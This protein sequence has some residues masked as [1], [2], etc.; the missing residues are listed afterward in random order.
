MAN[1]RAGIAIGGSAGVLVRL[2]G[3][4]RATISK[5]LPSRCRFY[6]SCA[7]YAQEAIQVHGAVRGGWMGIRRILRCHPFHPGGFDPVPR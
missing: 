4:Y 1:E 3:L 6:P 2:I 5:V 7:Q